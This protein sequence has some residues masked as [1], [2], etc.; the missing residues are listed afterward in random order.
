MLFC[1]IF[2]H[3]YVGCAGPVDVVKKKKKKN[4][5]LSSCSLHMAAQMF[6]YGPG[7]ASGL[8]PSEVSQTILAL[9]CS[10]TPFKLS[11]VKTGDIFQVVSLSV[12]QLGCCFFFFLE[13]L[14]RS[15]LEGQS[16][17]VL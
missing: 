3:C 2:M 7:R 6:D 10:F 1:Q 16:V 17:L 9:K 12:Q 5:C 8:H 15:D 13:K 4:V 14:C 11:T